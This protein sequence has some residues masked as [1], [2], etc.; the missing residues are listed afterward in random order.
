[1]S[2]WPQDHKEMKHDEHEH[3]GD[4]DDDQVMDMDMMIGVSSMKA[5][6]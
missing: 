2:W 4:H 5:K 1:M 3:G 6:V